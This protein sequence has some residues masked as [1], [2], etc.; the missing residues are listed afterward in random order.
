[1]SASDNAAPTHRTFTYRT[2]TTWSSGLSGTLTASGKPCLKVSTPPEFKGEGE[3]W[4]PEEMFVAAVEVCHMATFMSYASARGMVVLGYV[5]H[6]NGVLEYV[7]GDYR[8]TRIVI[9]PAITVPELIDESQVHAI[10]REAQE[11][12]LVANSI[13]SIVEVNPTIVVQPRARATSG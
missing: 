5:S 12:C 3:H 6:A 9:F 13:A 1:M 10:F 7:E 11:H 4:T 2:A 8:F